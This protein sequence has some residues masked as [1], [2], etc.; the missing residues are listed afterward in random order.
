MEEN[1]NYE[2]N[3]IQLKNKIKYI[4]NNK[5]SLNIKMNLH[6]CS[7]KTFFYNNVRGFYNGIF[8]IDIDK[9]LFSNIRRSRKSLL[10]KKSIL[11]T[12]LLGYYEDPVKNDNIID[13]GANKG[14]F[15]IKFLN[16]FQKTFL[17][18][19]NPKLIRGLEQR[20]IDDI[21]YKIFNCGIDIKNAIKK[22]YITSDTG[23]TLSSIKKQKE[24]LKKTLKKTD[25]TSVKNIKFYRL[26]FF[27]K[28]K[29]RK[30]DSIFLKIDTQG[31]DFEV[32]KS[33]GNKLKQI[34][35]IQI[36]MS[37]IPLYIKQE[38][39]WKILDFMKKN[40]FESIFFENGLRNNFG[41][42]IEYDCLFERQN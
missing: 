25:I 33:L 23:S 18:E 32:L 12:C 41:K 6:P 35:F 20:F 22:F 27:L 40:N 1:I 38:N 9:Y 31:N 2:L 26:D 30:N 11:H 29:I 34:K 3:M 7:G 17:I 4:K 13:I 19:P 15:A 14:D 24:I 42:M 16:T 39:H 28:N 21:N 36:E 10:L 5:L 8:I 37:I